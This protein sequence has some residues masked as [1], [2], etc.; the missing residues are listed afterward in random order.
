MG[1]EKEKETDIVDMT[2]CANI[3]DHHNPDRLGNEEYFSK[4]MIWTKVLKMFQ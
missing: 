2:I 1:R 4:H 3:A